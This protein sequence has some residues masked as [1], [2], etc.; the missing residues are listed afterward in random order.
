MYQIVL[1][2]AVRLYSQAYIE[3]DGAHTCIHLVYDVLLTACAFV[4][5]LTSKYR[6]FES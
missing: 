5:A 4:S 1:M 2:T 6:G 3:S